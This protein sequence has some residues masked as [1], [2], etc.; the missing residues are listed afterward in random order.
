MSESLTLEGIYRDMITINEV[1]DDSAIIQEAM[2]NVSRVIV[3][4]VDANGM[5]R[6]M[7]RSSVDES[8]ST[9]DR[10]TCNIQTGGML[11]ID[12]LGEDLKITVS[13]GGNSVDTFK[14]IKGSYNVDNIDKELSIIKPE[15]V[16]QS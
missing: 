15:L 16:S 10:L 5:P 2:F 7:Y 14:A 11:Q 3:T 4:S 1:V 8:I 9:D 12:K 13:A 6:I